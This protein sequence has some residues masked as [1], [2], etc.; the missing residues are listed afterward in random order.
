[1]SRPLLLS[2]SGR[3]GRR[4]GRGLGVT[5]LLLAL[6]TL[7][8]F[9]A[10]WAT[11]GDTPETVIHLTVNGQELHLS[12]EGDLPP[13]HAVVL[14]GLG[15]VLGLASLVA[16]MVLV[17][18]AVV[19]LAAAVAVAVLAGMGLPLLLLVAPGALLLSPI[20]L[21]GWLLWRALRPPRSIGA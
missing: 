20:L 13:A 19:L 14:A 12:P 4:L 16:V 18:L 11:L 6:A 7:G 5:V 3:V 10:A 21:L 15:T 9:A 8:A 1:M 17:P 2:A